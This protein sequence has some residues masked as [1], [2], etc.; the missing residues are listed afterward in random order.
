MS[1]VEKLANARNFQSVKFREFTRIVS[2]NKENVAIFF[3]GEDEKYYAIRINNI[4]PDIKWV[5]INSEGKSNVISLHNIIRSHAQYKKSLCLFFVDADFDDNTTLDNHTDIYVLPCYSIENLYISESAFKRILTAEFNLSKYGVDSEC[6][7][8]AVSTYQN[9]KNEY[10]L[11][12]SYFNYW[13]RSYRLMEKEGRIGGRLNINNINFNVL[14][15]VE[16]LTTQ[17]LYNQDAVCNLFPDIDSSIVVETTDSNEHPAWHLNSILSL[18][19]DAVRLGD[20]SS[21]AGQ[22]A[23]IP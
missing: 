18:V 17:K 16:L 5:G 21:C 15:K 7:D 20:L 3:E 22:R 9:S 4:R 19:K 10:L 14:I 6:F 23:S 12:I 8:K 11:A 2:T 1:R 13:I